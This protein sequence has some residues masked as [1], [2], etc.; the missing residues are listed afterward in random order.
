M[1][2]NEAETAKQDIYDNFKAIN[3]FIF[4]ALVWIL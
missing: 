1:Y 4:T 2:P 3:M